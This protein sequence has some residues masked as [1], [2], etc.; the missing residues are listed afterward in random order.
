MSPGSSGRAALIPTEQGKTK[1]K[2]NQIITVIKDTRAEITYNISLMP[3]A[4]TAC[5]GFA[6]LVQKDQF[7]P[8]TKDLILVQVGEYNEEEGIAKTEMKILDK[9]ENYL[10]DDKK[11]K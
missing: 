1:M 5:R 7:G 6:D 2:K 3:N 9:A 10:A 4:L 8:A 11:T